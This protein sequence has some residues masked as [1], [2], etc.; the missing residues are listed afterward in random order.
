[1][2]EFNAA[3]WCQAVILFHS[4]YLGY[5]GFMDY[6]TLACT[7]TCV[8]YRR[9]RLTYPGE[10]PLMVVPPLDRHK[11]EHR[12]TVR[13]LNDFPWLIYFPSVNIYIYLDIC[14]L[15]VGK[16]KI[17]CKVQFNLPSASVYLYEKTPLTTQFNILV[18]TP[19]WNLY[20]YRM[21]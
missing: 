1:M 8:C 18:R 17:T 4:F 16:D 6:V 7:A 20:S 19:R 3:L 2:H 14:R 12:F 15:I 13:S 5:H 9:S 10:C 11:L 21:I